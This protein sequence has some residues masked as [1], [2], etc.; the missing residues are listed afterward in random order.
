MTESEYPS[1]GDS[2]VQGIGGDVEPYNHGSTSVTYDPVDQEASEYARQT[3]QDGWNIS[4]VLDVSQ[5][6][7][8]AE[9]SSNNYKIEVPGSQPLLLKHS[10]LS[11]PRIQ[12]LINRCIAH[13]ANEGIKT[14]HII[15]TTEGS[16]FH[17]A[18]RG[19]SCL[20]NFIDGE[21][22]DG[23]RFEI[24]ET[25]RELAR[26][27]QVLQRLPYRDEIKLLK[28]V[29]I[30]HDRD[31]LARVAEA[32]SRSTG[33]SEFDDSVRANLKDIL[34]RSAEIF[35]ADIEGLPVQV[36]HLDLH[37]HNILFDRESH[38]VI[39]VLDFD[40]LQVSQR[41]RDVGYTMHRLAR[42]Y[43]RKTERQNDIGADIRGRADCF[44]EA[45]LEINELTGNEMRMIP[46]AIQDEAMGRLISTLSGHYLKGD[47]TWSFELSKELTILQESLL[48]AH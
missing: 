39:A 34:D 8:A 25:A 27:H 44:L 22:F 33:S 15:P 24:R 31:E 16:S 9:K 47:D 42:T 13:C 12:E 28:G 41:A 19:I 36:I 5:I 29:L 32:V 37:P 3:L 2:P 23:S 35:D 7:E 11:D 43:G 17:V 38:Q 14:S 18:E 21:H 46:W 10:H 4:P 40:P 45:Y 48:F 6:H 30:K 1:H 20:Y 26:L